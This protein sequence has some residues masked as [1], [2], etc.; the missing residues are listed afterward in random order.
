VFELSYFD[1]TK[2]ST[3]CDYLILAGLEA[4][5]EPADLLEAENTSTSP[6]LQGV[7]RFSVLR[8][9]SM[10]C[11]PNSCYGFPDPTFQVDGSPL[12]YLVEFIGVEESP[13]QLAKYRELMSKYFGP[14][15]GILVERGTLHCFV[16]LQN[17]EILFSDQSTVPWNQL[18][19]SDDWGAGGEDEWV[20]VYEELF[21][22]EF[23]C[24]L[25]SVWADLP[26]T[27]DSRADCHGRLIPQLCIK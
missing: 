8:S 24:D 7:P 4:G 9:A 16:A 19:I 5:A 11:T 26:S 20:S 27:D 12:V 15:N 25:D 17:N 23:S 13:E 2:T 1:P 21:R 3:V 6:T 14:A 22:T 10:S 18:H